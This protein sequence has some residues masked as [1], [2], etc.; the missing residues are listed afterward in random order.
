[1][2]TEPLNSPKEN[3]NSYWVRPGSFLAG[4]YPY[5]P[6]NPAKLQAL[7][8]A[9]VT[10]FVDLTEEGHNPDYHQ[11]LTG[12][13]HHR[14]SSEDDGTPTREHMEKVLDL[15]DASIDEGKIPYVHCKGGTGRTGTTVGCWL[16][17]HGE[18]G[19][20][21]YTELQDLWQASAK[22]AKGP[23]PAKENQIAFVKAWK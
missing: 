14:M 10:V 15:L 19:E 5:D 4:E 18:S 17:R 23:S 13:E 16:A 1:M 20:A 12:A 21:A 7:L 11:E 6:E 3:P 9:G 2:T 22:S 8:D